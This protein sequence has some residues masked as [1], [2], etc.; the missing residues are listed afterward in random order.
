M[1][2][3]FTALT[4]LSFFSIQSQVTFN[5]IYHEYD[6]LG[7]ITDVKHGD[8][9]GDNIDDFLLYTLSSKTIQIGINNNLQKPTFVTI[10]ENLDARNIAVHD[11][12]QDGDQDIIGS[13]VFD[14]EAYVWKNDGNGNFTAELLSIPDYNSIHFADLN[15]DDVDE[16]ILGIAG[17]L[18][19]YST[20]GGT[21]TLLSTVTN[22]VPDAIYAFDYNGDEV[23]DIAGTYGF[24][25]VKVYQQSSNLSF[26]EIEIMP[27]SFNNN[28][29]VTSD[30]NDDMI[31]DFLLFNQFSTRTTILK[32]TSFGNYEEEILPENNGTNE[33]TAFGYIDQDSVMD[34]FY[35]EEDTQVDGFNSVYLGA[36]NPLTQQI[37]NENYSNLAGGGIADLDGDG[38]NDIF[39]Y[40]N[41]FFNKGLVFFLNEA[42]V[43]EDNDGFFSDVDC[44][45]NN[46]NVNP[47]QTEIPYNGV[48]DDCDANTLDDDLDQD[49]FVL[50]S[51]CDDDNADINPNQTEIPYN[52][53]DED[54]NP[55][56][57]DDDLDQDG[58]VLADDCDDTNPDAN[59]N[60]TE[61][62]N[63]GIDEDCD[64]MDLMVSIHELSNWTINIFPNPATERIN[65]ELPI[66]LDLSVKLFDLTG[67]II[68]SDFNSLSIQVNHLQE[69]I[70]LL[71]VTNT[72]NGQF[73]R[74]KIT[75]IK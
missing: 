50:A 39:V 47:G 45:D 7:F 37:F 8:F 15:G 6:D 57:L 43:D 24:E 62:P 68:F 25:G 1:K 38:D 21:I 42:P 17:N 22:D 61:I 10:S 13:I 32:S 75:V 72:S 64:G 40:A 26:T 2:Y 18:N 23:M 58:F 69:G 44:D 49:G 30:I 73:I 12:D 65:L 31:P 59:P 54:C 14:D 48:D 41:D 29:I 46:P 70:Y 74:E 66:E 53:I 33:F 51:D 19:I 9:N 20:T 27:T 4:L 56:T 67:Q 5:E 16:M 55:N 36:N 60:G 63:N 35:H 34:I 28:K 3:L 11:F 71:E 52:G